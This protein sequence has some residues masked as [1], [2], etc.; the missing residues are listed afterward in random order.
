MANTTH[1]AMFTAWSP[2]RSRY[3]EII[4]RSS[5]STPRAGVAAQKLDERVLGGDE[6]AVH[7]VVHVDDP[8]GPSGQIPAH[9]GVD[10]AAHHLHRLRAHLLNLGQFALVGRR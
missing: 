10:G 7:L 1:S 6:E 5:A 3:L 2:M 9:E 4:R 8:L